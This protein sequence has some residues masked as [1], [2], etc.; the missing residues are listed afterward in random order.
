[1]TLR[2]RL[3]P[4]PF[5]SPQPSWQVFRRQQRFTNA[6]S[7]SESAESAPPEAPSASSPQPQDMANGAI[8]DM[9]IRHKNH[10]C[11]NMI[12]PIKRPR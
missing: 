1:M 10:M 7:A 5:F 11:V 8:V 4:P 6:T 9:G 3:C 2:A 12:G